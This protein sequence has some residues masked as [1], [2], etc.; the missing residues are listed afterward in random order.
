MKTKLTNIFVVV[1]VLAELALALVS[2]ILS[3]TTSMPVRSLLSSEGIRWFLGHYSELL[4]T[5][6]LVWLILLSMSYGT[7]TASRLFSPSGSYR[8][9]MGRRA[10]IAVLF[11]FM[12]VVGLLIA[13]PH[14]I[15]LSATG[16]VF[17]SPFSKALFPLLAFGVLLCSV[18]YGLVVRSFRGLNDIVGSLL[19]GM[20]KGA[21]L[22]LFYILLV[23]FYES[24]R[25]V[26][27]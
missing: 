6:I 27:V 8:E 20:A 23:Q 18:V 26:F 10:V 25:F 24:L 13:V 15:L 17:P 12:V 9:K 1:L 14:A 22:V 3:S 5:P 2:W 7:L 4:L 11:A 16:N 19:N 21:P